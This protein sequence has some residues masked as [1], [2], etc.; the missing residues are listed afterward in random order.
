MNTSRVSTRTFPMAGLVVALASVLALQGCSSD[1]GDVSVADL[2][3]DAANSDAANS[4]GAGSGG[5]GSGS[6]GY[7][8]NIPSDT[9]VVAAVT[10][11][12]A[13]DGEWKDGALRLT[14]DEGSVEDIM[15]HIN[16][17]AISHLI[18]DEEGL[19]LVYPDGE[20]DC[21]EEA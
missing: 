15:A 7:T 10:A 6:G 21:R 14:Y 9:M 2:I 17:S 5:S 18:K 20:V 11:T 16:C 19:I 12:R 1:S 8:S 4:D 13:K 3:S